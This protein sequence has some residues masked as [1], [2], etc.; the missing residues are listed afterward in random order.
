MQLQNHAQPGSCLPLIS[1][2]EI[3][4]G[5]RSISEHFLEMTNHFWC[6]AVGLTEWL[7]PTWITPKNC[8]SGR[9][10][11]IINYLPHD[12]RI[13][14]NE[15]TSTLE[16]D[17]S[18]AVKKRRLDYGTFQKWRKDLDRECLT[19]SWLDFP[20]V[21]SKLKCKVCS[22]FKHNIKGRKNFSIMTNHFHNLTNQNTLCLVICPCNTWNYFNHWISSHRWI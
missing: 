18:A 9:R 20:A 11:Q 5:H 6:C 21:I 16:D 3:T 12:S 1:E 7:T 17:S 19:V 14:N 10:Y 22:E 13:F 15:E 8:T 4:S 2:V